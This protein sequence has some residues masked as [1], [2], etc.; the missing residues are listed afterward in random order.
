MM[1]TFLHIVSMQGSVGMLCCDVNCAFER[2]A[3]GWSVHL[4]TLLGQRWEVLEWGTALNLWGEQKHDKATGCNSG[5]TS[6][7]E[8]SSSTSSPDYGP[9][10]CWIEARSEAHSKNRLGNREEKREECM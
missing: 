9:Y 1:H 2:F 10:D 3:E 5:V 8:G 4:D 6:K 7:R